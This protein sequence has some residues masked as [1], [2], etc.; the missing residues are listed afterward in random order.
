[1]SSCKN[2]VEKTKRKSMKM[3]GGEIIIAKEKTIQRGGD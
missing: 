3:E 2:K 1:V